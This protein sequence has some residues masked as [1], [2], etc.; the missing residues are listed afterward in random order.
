MVL[1]VVLI[2]YVVHDNLFIE[3]DYNIIFAKAIC[4]H[5]NKIPGCCIC[6]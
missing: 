4:Y 6:V 2:A 3:G 5:K 1:M